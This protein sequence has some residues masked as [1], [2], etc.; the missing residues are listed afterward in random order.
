MWKMVW[1]W[2]RGPGMLFC[3]KKNYL[4]LEKK[5]VKSNKIFLLKLSLISNWRKITC[6]KLHAFNVLFHSYGAWMYITIS[7]FYALKDI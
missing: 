2:L 3:E 1:Q 6:Q 7:T 5:I 4:G